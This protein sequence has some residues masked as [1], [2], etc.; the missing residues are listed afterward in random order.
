MY[1]RL[2]Q[3][4]RAAAALATAV[5]VAL[6]LQPRALNAEDRVSFRGAYFR[7]ASNRVI[8]PMMELTKDLPGGYDVGGHFLVDAISSASIAQGARVDNVFTETRYEGSVGLGITRD[9]QRLAGFI[10]YSHEPDYKSYTGGLSYN[11]EVWD[12]TGT[13]GVNLAFT[14]DDIHPAL[15]DDKNLDVWFA[16]VGY[17]QALSPTTMAQGVYETYYQSGFLANPYSSDGNLGREDVPTRRLRHALAARL[18]QYIPRATLGMQLHYRLYYDQ[19]S[20]FETGPWGILGHTLEARLS[21]ALGPN[22]EVRGTYR[23]YTQSAANFWCNTIVAMGGDVSCY[24]M[25]PEYHSVDIKFGDM[26]TQV[27]ELK[28]IWDLRLLN[29][30]A[31]DFFSAGTF[32]V[33]YGYYFEGTPYGQ[34][35]NDRN[36]P[37]V[38]GELPFSREYGGAHLIQTGYSLPF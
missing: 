17:T 12:R 37:P 5:A 14:H 8:Q 34:Q 20:L 18:A 22:L 7:E 10:R 4:Q 9:L 2:L 13:V 36:A 29:G 16:G 26:R 27:A 6:V 21:K 32:D 33:A 30:T 23:F 19:L 1:G 11:R 25:S 3:P 28:L 31:L 24:G 38:I 15:Q 35:F